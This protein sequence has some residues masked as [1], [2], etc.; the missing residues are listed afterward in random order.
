MQRSG[1]R[2]RLE[3]REAL[4]PPPVPLVTRR[5]VFAAVGGFDEALPVAY[6]DVDFCFA[7]RKTGYWV[8]VT[9]FAAL[10][11]ELFASRR[12][13]PKPERQRDWQE[14]IRHL[15]VKWPDQWGNDPYLAVSD[16]A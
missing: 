7:V 15:Q 6:N 13:V 10:N 9:P 8:V 1:Q 11:H 5:D 2:E 12:D 4:M 3:R 14:S 16:R